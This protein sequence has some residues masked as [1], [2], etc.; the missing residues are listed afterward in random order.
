MTRDI[1]DVLEAVPYLGFFGALSNCHLT[2]PVGAFLDSLV[3]T[4]NA[5]APSRL[6]ISDIRLIGAD[7]KPLDVGDISHVQLSSVEGSDHLEDVKQ[8]MLSGALPNSRVEVAPTLRVAFS[9]RVYIDHVM[10]YN[11]ADRHW[12]DGRFVEVSGEDGGNVVFSYINADPDAAIR[13]WE[14]LGRLPSIGV[15]PDNDAALSVGAF[16]KEIK[17]KLA[18]GLRSG[19]VRLSDIDV[20][21]AIQLVAPARDPAEGV[22]AND[23]V[24]L[25]AFLAPELIRAEWFSTPQLGAF[26]SLLPTEADLDRLMDAANALPDLHERFAGSLRISKHSINPSILI[27]DG[28]KY[29][30]MSERVL[31]ELRTI[32]IPCIVAYGTLLGAAR[33]G[34]F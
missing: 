5:P 1:A 29:M 20:N 18:E 32:D 15:S 30:E 25:A 10:L 28:D 12:T 24:I 2:I 22:D 23:L 19:A 26:S 13:R 14:A 33:A 9:G 6:R 17:A 4:I 3:V 21:S 7:R 16:A 31:G 34:E 27:R 8:Q 11:F